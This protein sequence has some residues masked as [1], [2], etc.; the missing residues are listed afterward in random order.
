MNGLRFAVWLVA[1]AATASCQYYVDAVDAI[2]GR[3]P[4]ESQRRAQARAAAEAEQDEAKAAK[5]QELLKRYESALADAETQLGKMHARHQ[6]VD[7]DA[8]EACG[9]GSLDKAATWI[10][11]EDDVLKDATLP[12]HKLRQLAYPWSIFNS[13]MIRAVFLDHQFRALDASE[14]EACIEA[15]HKLAEQTHFVVVDV[16]IVGLPKV[17]YANQKFTPGLVEA[18]A[19]VYVGDETKCKLQ[20]SAT[21]E[22]AIEVDSRRE[23]QTF[24]DSDD[25]FDKALDDLWERLLHALEQAAQDAGAD[26]FAGMPESEATPRAD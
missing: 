24:A 5:H 8:L 10:V 1:L 17:D 22:A 9:K 19:I 7:I 14:R 18:A 20:A 13:A 3:D 6:A 4:E 12:E 25:I 16:R 26:E 2:Q 11:V 23:G 15:S 21:N